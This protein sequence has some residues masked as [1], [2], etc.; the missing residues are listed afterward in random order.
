MTAARAW[1]PA[2]SSAGASVLLFA[3]VAA[4]GDSA[5]VP[6]LGAHTALPPWDA[7]L[8]PPSELVTVLL[9]LADVLGAFAVGLG[10]RALRRG[11]GAPAPRLVAAAGAAAVALLVI[12]PPLGSA[13]HL[14]YVAYG[15][16]AAA[17]DDPYQVRP[18]QWRGG[19]DPVAGA[20]QPPWRSTPSVYGPVATAVQ[21]GVAVAGGGSLR[22]T[23][24]G[25][26][27]VAGASFLAVGL[28]LDLLTRR[29]PVARG[30]AAVLW[31]LNPLLLGQL[32]LGSH[33]DVLA[34]AFALASIALV[35]RA[36]V[37]AGMLLAAAAD[38]KLPY[39]VAGL[40]ACWGLRRLPRAR[41]AASLAWGSLGL[42]A[43]A[44]PAQLWAGPQVFDQLR[45]A[46][47]MVSLATAW[48]PVVD[49]AGLLIGSDTARS[50]VT[51]LAGLLAA[52]LALRLAR[53]LWPPSAVLRD[54]VGRDR[55]AR[56][57]VMADQVTADAARAIV[58]LSAAWVLT[59][60]Y[61][62]P[63]YDALVW[64]PLA[65]VGASWLDGV[66]LVRLAVLAVAYVPGRVVGHVATVEQVTLA[67]R[68]WVAPAVMFVLV[69][70]VVRR[71]RP[72]AP[73]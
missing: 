4:M 20:V 2:V 19:H 15:R 23:V 16:I 63:W 31:T 34:A 1:L 3:G 51:P 18:D 67:V 40:A 44:V 62:L 50:V 21:A 45:L 57:Q 36:P 60:P 52:W 69:V 53:G 5:A 48:R 8:R 6:G 24:W 33:V 61:A 46:G 55:A 42:L 66:L 37:V 54:Q 29:D 68:S 12:V 59:A 47:R 22:R 9:V 71:T 35:P 58:V 70:A 28:I 65:L 49:G 25:W 32:V 41:L 30:R 64:A 73:S 26:Q 14:S 11:A 56:D 10:L 13:D 72:A 17:G 38:T 39:A 7:G 43:V 27:L